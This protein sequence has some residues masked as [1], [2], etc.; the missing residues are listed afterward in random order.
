MADEKA[1]VCDAVC[2][3]LQIADLAVHF[4]N[5]CFT[6]GEIVPGSGE[7]SARRHRQI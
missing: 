3:E 5:G 6:N 2:I 1:T 4:R 7:G